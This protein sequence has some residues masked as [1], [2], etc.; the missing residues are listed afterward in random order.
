MPILDFVW[1]RGFFWI[2]R[3]VIRE[4]EYW[5]TR[6]PTQFAYT[7]FIPNFTD[8]INPDTDS[9]NSIDVHEA[10][11]WFYSRGYRRPGHRDG[12]LDRILMRCQSLLIYKSQ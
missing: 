4:L 11:L 12:L 9:Q 10:Y 1:M 8:Y 6:R 3:R 2:P 7:H 5:L